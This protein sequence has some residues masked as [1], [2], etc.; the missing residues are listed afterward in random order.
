M[1]DSDKERP[2][3]RMPTLGCTVAGR[4]DEFFLNTLADPLL[5]WEH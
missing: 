3:S 1:A 5:V 2:F 4:M